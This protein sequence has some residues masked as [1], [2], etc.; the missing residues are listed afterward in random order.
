MEDTTKKWVLFGST[1]SVVILLD[2]WS[3]YMVRTRWELQNMELIPGWLNFHYTQNSGMALGIDILDTFYVSIIALLATVLIMWYIIRYMKQAPVSFMFL[4]GL[5]IGGAVGN[6]LDRIYMG[7]LEGYG[8]VFEGHVVDFIHFSLRINDWAVFPYI[9]N[10]ADMGISLAVILF[11]LF[12]KKFMPPE[13]PKVE[14]SP[15]EEASSA[16][17]DAV[18][19]EAPTTPP[20]ESLAPSEGETSTEEPDTKKS[21]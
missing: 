6:L 18:Q 1:A 9:F 14:E 20:S 2:Q 16:E 10:V 7:I 21:S 12:G 19:S 3:K 4:T 17:V 8:G 13:E 15:S 11:L 5:V